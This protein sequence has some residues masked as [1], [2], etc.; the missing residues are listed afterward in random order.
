M[1]NYQREKKLI[2]CTVV[3]TGNSP[4]VV[5]THWGHK[6]EFVH[7]TGGANIWKF[8]MVTGPGQS[9]GQRCESIVTRFYDY[10]R[11]NGEPAYFDDCQQVSGVQD[12]RTWKVELLDENKVPG[13]AG[14]K[15]TGFEGR[16]EFDDDELVWMWKMTLLRE[17]DGACVGVGCYSIKLGDLA[18]EP[19]YVKHCE[20]QSLPQYRIWEVT[21]KK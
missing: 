17:L 9:Q 1:E 3:E 2:E 7:E 21:R 10:A 5:A 4:K 20:G 8:T 18:Q 12:R 19:A 14:E 16:F 15:A 11:I 6:G 13:D